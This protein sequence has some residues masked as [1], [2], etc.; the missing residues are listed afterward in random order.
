MSKWE[1]IVLW[2]PWVFMK[3]CYY[4]VKTLLLK[5]WLTFLEG[6][7]IVAD[8]FHWSKTLSDTEK[9]DWWNQKRVWGAL[10]IRPCHNLTR[11]ILRQKLILKKRFKK[12]F[13][14]YFA[15]HKDLLF[16]RELSFVQHL[17]FRNIFVWH[18]RQQQNDEK[19]TSTNNKNVWPPDYNI[20]I[21][22]MEIFRQGTAV[23]HFKE[24]CKWNNKLN[25][26]TVRVIL[27]HCYSLRR[28]SKV[29]VDV[30]PQNW[31]DF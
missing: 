6:L 16:D 7:I 25:I 14:K 28:V 12:I 17:S 24:S 30:W 8:S 3:A 22:K 4:R 15:R 20:H 26:I 1:Y 9:L 23:K 29:Q 11:P 31:P 27:L 18:R 13:S 5:S 10:K 19:K 2:Q 21:P